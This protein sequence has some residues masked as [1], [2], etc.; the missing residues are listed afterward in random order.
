MS[1]FKLVAAQPHPY[2]KGNPLEIYKD[3]Q[4]L[5]NRLFMRTRLFDLVDREGFHCEGVH[6]TTVCLAAAKASISWSSEAETYIALTKE[7]RPSK[8]ESLK[9]FLRDRRL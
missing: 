8:S 6:P 9:F 4:L 5:T 7:I 2:A 3:N 1:K